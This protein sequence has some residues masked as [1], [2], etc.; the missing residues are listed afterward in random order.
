MTLMKS[1]IADFKANKFVDV[2]YLEFYDG[3]PSLHLAFDAEW[4]FQKLGRD[5]ESPLCL[6]SRQST[7]TTNRSTTEARFFSG[8]FP[9]LKK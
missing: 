9:W 2:L 1:A 4:G 7:I 6:S 5:G 3:Y 8:G